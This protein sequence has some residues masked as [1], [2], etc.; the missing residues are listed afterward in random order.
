MK[1]KTKNLGVFITHECG[2]DKNGLGC[3]FCRV[4]GTEDSIHIQEK[5]LKD[6]LNTFSAIDTIEIR[7][8]DPKDNIDGL[9]R[10]GELLCA[11]GVPVVS[12]KVCNGG[13]RFQS[14]VDVLKF[15]QQNSRLKVRGE[16]SNNP[17]L[18]AALKRQGFD[19]E[20]IKNEVREIIR[21]N[22]DLDLVLL[23]PPRIIE[24]EGRA[25]NFKNAVAALPKPIFNNKKSAE[26]GICDDITITADGFVS[27]FDWAPYKKVR[28]PG[29]NY[30][31]L[32]NERFHSIIEK[33]R[34]KSLNL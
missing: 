28:L 23:P 33:E 12:L 13:V 18:D 8:G 24:A 25:V 20:S 16:V 26:S 19:P 9:K 14:V 6:I 15:I 2:I 3:G 31:C 10:F 7:G 5:Y 29:N 4:G 32:K 21:Q 27:A 11:G 34:Q 17:F 30:G 1:Y 22:P